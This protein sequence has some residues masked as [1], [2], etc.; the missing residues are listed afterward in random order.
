MCDYLLCITRL[1]CQNGLCMSVGH[2][3]VLCI[4]QLPALP[5]LHM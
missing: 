5:V 1:D 2:P 3:E 4:V